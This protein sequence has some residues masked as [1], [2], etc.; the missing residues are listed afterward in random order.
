MSNMGAFSFGFEKS[1]AGGS[2]VERAIKET[3]GQLLPWRGSSGMGRALGY[4]SY[5]PDIY[6]GAKQVGTISDADDIAAVKVRKLKKAY[7]DMI[8]KRDARD[9]RKSLSREVK[10]QAGE[11]LSGIGGGIGLG[12]LGA[13]LLAAPFTGGASIAA[14][15]VGGMAGGIAG[16]KLGRKGYRIITERDR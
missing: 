1:A 10:H 8:S 3:H 13:G 2:Y 6:Q 5:I 15:I 11:G 12:A 4:A 7:G 16:D 9:L 14:V